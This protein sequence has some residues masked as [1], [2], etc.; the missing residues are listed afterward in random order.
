MARN[1]TQNR[2]QCAYAKCGVVWH[3][4]A[5]MPRRFRIK[6]NVASR[7]MDNLEGPVLAQAFDEFRARKISR[8]FHADF[9]SQGKTFVPHQMK[10][11]RLR[12]RLGG[13]KKISPH[14]ILHSFAKRMPIIALCDD[15][16]RQALGHKPAIALLN[17][18][19]N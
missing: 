2:I 1:E 9:S 8:Q 4:D 5:L 19:E 16:F 10:S 11:D 17:H 7:L 15:R 13:V 6:D 12:Q 18:F 14:G 3:W